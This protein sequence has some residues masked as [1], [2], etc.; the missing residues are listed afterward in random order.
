MVVDEDKSVAIG[1]HSF[2]SIVMKISKKKRNLLE[3][4]TPSFAKIDEPFQLVVLVHAIAEE[5]TVFE[6]GNVAN[7]EVLA[8]LDG[9]SACLTIILIKRFD[10]DKHLLP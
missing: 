5:A 4:S 3:D 10:T 6:L 9:F 1:H 8:R 7:E 2:K